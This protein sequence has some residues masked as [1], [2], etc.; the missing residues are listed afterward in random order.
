MMLR[1]SNKLFYML[2]PSLFLNQGDTKWSR[3]DSTTAA[4]NKPIDTNGSTRTIVRARAIR[5]QQMT[6]GD[7]HTYTQLLKEGIVMWLKPICKWRRGGTR[8]LFFFFRRLA[9]N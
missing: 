4:G 7:K 6:R 3:Q 8:V 2:T 9:D 1:M 5:I